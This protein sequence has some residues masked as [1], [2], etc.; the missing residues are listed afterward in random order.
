YEDLDRLE[1][2]EWVLRESLRLYPPLTIIMR[3]AIDDFE[4]HGYRIPAKTAVGLFPVL[5]GR[6]EQW[7]SSPDAFDPER[8]SPARAEHKRHPFAWVPFGGGAH[9]C[10]GLHF[11]EMQVKAVLHPLLRSCRIGVAPGYTMPYQLAPI[12]RPKDGL[13]IR[14]EAL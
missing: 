13:P 12:A 4:I 14:F 6:L 9:M 5:T 3:R 7:W 1:P 11:A 10:L 2:I 8:F